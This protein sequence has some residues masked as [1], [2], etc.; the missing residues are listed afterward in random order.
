[1][2]RSPLAAPA[3]PPEPEPAADSKL[4][5]NYVL[6]VLLVAYVFNFVDRNLLAALLEPIKRDLGSTDTQMGLLIGTTFALFYTVL[7][8]PIARWADLGNR[9]SILALGLALWSGAT[10]LSGL[11][12]SYLQLMLA[13]VGVG[14]G[15]AAGSPP[16]HSLISDYFPPER[17][18]RALSVYATGNYLGLLV[19]H[20][21]GTWLAQRHGWRI[22]F[23]AAGLPGLALAL[24]VRL[25]VREPPRGRSESRPSGP[26]TATLREAL[27]FLWRQRSYNYINAAGAFSALLGYGFGHWSNAFLMRVHGMTLAEAGSWIGPIAASC[28]VSGALVGGAIVDRLARR[29][30]RW[31]LWLPGLSGLVTFPFSAAFALADR[32]VVLIAFGA[33]A[34]LHAL[35]VGPMFTAMQALAQLRMRALAVAI[36]MF[37][38]NL[39]GLGLGP[40]LVGVLNDSLRAAL[41]DGGIRY[42]LL[43]VSCTGPIAGLLFLAG[44]RTMREDLR[45]ARSDAAH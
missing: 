35:Y 30:A 34:F 44:A 11:A 45:A 5:A 28:G 40:L 24:L 6:G 18:A 17:R 41:G 9:R 15:E 23:V 37:V 14:I 22:A 39:I 21:A 31:Y 25:S 16:S 13:R 12:R 20:V 1:V 29:D 33:H 8:I 2:T 10:A 42:S 19:A 4:Y 43:A 3:P 7:G 27:R 32:S 26:H 36:H 38:V